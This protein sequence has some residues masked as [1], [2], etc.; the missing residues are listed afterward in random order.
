LSEPDQFIAVL[1]HDQPLPRSLDGV[2]I[3]YTD[4]C[5]KDAWTGFFFRGDDAVA[6]AVAKCIGDDVDVRAVVMSDLRSEDDIGEFCGRF[7]ISE[8]V[9]ARLERQPLFLDEA[10]S[11]C[12]IVRLKDIATANALLSTGFNAGSAG[13]VELI[14]LGS[15]DA[16]AMS[17]FVR[18]NPREIS[19]QRPIDAVLGNLRLA[20]IAD[21]TLVLH[22]G[23]PDSPFFFALCGDAQH[24]ASLE[25][26]IGDCGGQFLAWL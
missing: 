7:A 21:A 1:V 6:C 18:A 15:A 24:R 22:C 5:D 26:L 3:S 4:L 13:G 8:H 9:V 16:R 12:A 20:R 19:A 11:A 10:D 14:A 17:S 23:H 2:V 25:A